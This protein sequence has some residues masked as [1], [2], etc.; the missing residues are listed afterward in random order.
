MVGRFRMSYRA[1]TPEFA[2]RDRL[3]RA[4]G[5]TFPVSA[6]DPRALRRYARRVHDSHVRHSRQRPACEHSLQ[7]A[8]RCRRGD[9]DG[10]SRRRRTERWAEFLNHKK[11]TE[12][13]RPTAPKAVGFLFH[14]L[15]FAE[16]HHEPMHTTNTTEPKRAQ[17][18]SLDPRE[19]RVL[20]LSLAY[21]RAGLAPE[22]ALQSAIADFE[23]AYAEEQPC[24][25]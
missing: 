8:S 4:F 25:P 24:L 21:L 1:A 14:R 9:L 3:P 7:Q 23:C 16:N 6:L 11:Q 15:W 17:P 2:S 13:I 12:L 19:D 18:M 20:A 10:K 22:D 5:G